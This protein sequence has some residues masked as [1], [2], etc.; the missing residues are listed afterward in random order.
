MTDV[1]KK[2]DAVPAGRREPSQLSRGPWLTDAPEL[3]PACALR[4][5]RL[6]DWNTTGIGTGASS[7]AGGAAT[8]HHFFPAGLE[9]EVGHPARGKSASRTPSLCD[10]GR[11]HGGLE[12][13]PRP[14]E[15]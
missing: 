9:M 11:N 12:K 7:R 5:T 2:Q 6:D 15:G 14:E 10:K 13:I 8:R 3:R 4:I 1:R